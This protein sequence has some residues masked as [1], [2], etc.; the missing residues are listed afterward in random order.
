VETDSAGVRLDR[1]IA[2]PYGSPSDSLF[3]EGPGFTGHQTDSATGLI[4]MQARYYDPVGQ[5]FFSVDPVDV[6]ATNGGNFSRYWYA[7]NNPYR[8]TDPD[9]RNP[10]NPVDA[11]YFAKDVG[12][13]LVTEMVAGA[14]FVMGDDDVLNMAL[15]DMSAGALDAGA[16]TVGMVSLVP[17]VGKE[18][19]IGASIVKRAGDHGK[20]ERHGDSGRAMAKAEKRVA[21]LTEQ[22]VTAAGREAKKIEQK[23]KNIIRDAQRKDKGEEHSRREKK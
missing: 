6:S 21:E 15:D 23:I 4:Y 20:N 3:R 14:A 22:L 18:I 9:G 13:L 1:A 10:L 19:K 11:Y 7:N 12:G 5:R 16:S 2:L 8:Y 17:G